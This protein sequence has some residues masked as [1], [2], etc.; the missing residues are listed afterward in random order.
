MFNQLLKPTF[1]DAVPWWYDYVLMTDPY[2]PPKL[3]L[4]DPPPPYPFRGVKINAD[5]KQHP[6]SL[7]SVVGLVRSNTDV[8][9]Q[10]VVRLQAFRGLNGGRES[11]FTIE[12]LDKDGK[13]LSTASLY[14]TPSY[15][16]CS[17]CSKD[18]DYFPHPPYAFQAFLR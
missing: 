2:F 14:Q 13:I 5:P 9:V 6:E 11:Q 15:A 16:G 1:I 7:I 17:C 18:K 12:L 10:S 8:S 4:P 3:W